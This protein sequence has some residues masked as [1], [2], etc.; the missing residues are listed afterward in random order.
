MPK[1][2]T[3]GSREGEALVTG[4]KRMGIQF[5][6]E[7]GPEISWETDFGIV[8]GFANIMTYFDLPAVRE[9]LLKTAY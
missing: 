7:N 6:V 5:N 8:R 4:L 1:V 9:E 2:V 3:D